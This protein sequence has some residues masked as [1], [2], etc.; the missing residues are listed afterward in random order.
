MNKYINCNDENAISESCK[1]LKKGG[2]II[3][4]TDTI[5]GFGCDATNECAIKKINKI[6]KRA[7]P[8]SVIA[9][10]IETALK[11]MEIKE[12]ES[13]LIKRKMK[14]G[15]TVI[16]PIKNNICSSIIRGKNQTLGIRVPEHN[17]CKKLAKKYSKPITTT[18]VNKTGQK[19]F[20][21]INQIVKKFS[22]DVDLILGDG[23][24]N[25]KGSKIY[26]FQD[27]LWDRLR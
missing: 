8:M 24:I 18:S 13:V 25:G 4:P 10:K 23:D 19:A 17:F 5:Y 22:K 11:W 20:T 9:P 1:I 16:V 3:Y 21:S 6:K 26:V 14:N 12:N 7:G 15:N 2:I 27:G